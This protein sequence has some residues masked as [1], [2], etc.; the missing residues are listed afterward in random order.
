MPFG[1]KKSVAAQPASI[2]PVDS[3]ASAGINV[4]LGDGTTFEG[5]LEYTG[6]AQISGVFHGEIISQGSLSIGPGGRVDGEIKVGQLTVSGNLKGT[7]ACARKASLLRSA[8]FDG[9]LRTPKL[10][11]EAGAEFEGQISMPTAK[12]LQND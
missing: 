9:E 4:F 1:R 12:S 3:G 2:A 7:A 11:M 10:E 5:R 6:T 8:V